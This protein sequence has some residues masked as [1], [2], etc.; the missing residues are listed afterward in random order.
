MPLLIFV[1]DYNP[2]VYTHTRTAEKRKIRDLPGRGVLEIITRWA[3]SV[4]T[5]CFVSIVK[6]QTIT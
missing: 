4:L 6:F 1:D 2:G 3:R 5:E